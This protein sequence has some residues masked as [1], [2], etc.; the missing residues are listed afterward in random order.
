MVMR[1]KG[2]GTLISHL[3]HGVGGAFP[4]KKSPEPKAARKTCAR[5]DG[6][7][8]G[9]EDAQRATKAWHPHQDCDSNVRRARFGRR[10][11]RLRSR[12]GVRRP[13]TRNSHARCYTE[14]HLLEK[15][16]IHLP[17]CCGLV[18]LAAIS[19]FLGSNV[20]MRCKG[21]EHA[22]VWPHREDG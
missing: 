3:P 6:T 17:L 16:R 12:E 14:A 1:V 15:P 11:G 22:D 21:G 10:R 8:D 7:H 9:I 19:R 4:E 20:L 5:R 13:R 18:D 2:A